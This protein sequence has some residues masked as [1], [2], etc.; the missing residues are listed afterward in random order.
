MIDIHY[1]QNLIVKTV[2]LDNSK[3]IFFDN[4]F[5]SLYN[6]DYI[7]LV[8]KSAIIKEKYKKKLWLLR[9][10]KSGIFYD[11]RIRSSNLNLNDNK[12]DETNP[13]K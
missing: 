3:L 1:S 7:N 13:F 12:L 6:E 8:K 9:I 5:K 4:N 10:N 11:Y 2:K